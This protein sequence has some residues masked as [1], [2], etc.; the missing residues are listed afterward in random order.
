MN[1]AFI[2]NTLNGGGAERFTANI[3]NRFSEES[4]NTVYVI[5]G[6]KADNDYSVNSEVIRLNFLTKNLLIDVKQILN[7]SKRYNFD[8]IVGIDIYPNFCVCL[9]RLFSN[10]RCIISERNAPKQ[11][12]I[13]SKSR[14]LRWVL[15]RFADGYVF[16]TNGAKKFYSKRIQRKSVVIHNPIRE[17]LPVKSNVN[18]NEIVAVGRLNEQKNYPMLI[19][20]FSIVHRK[21]SDYKLRIFGEGKLKETLVSLAQELNI[22]DYVFFEGFTL[23]VHDSIKDSS[24]FVMTSDFEG[25]P[26]AL[27][28]AMAMG[29]PVVST[30]CP[31]GGPGELIQDGVNGMLCHVGDYEECE[32]KICEII[33]NSKLKNEL[34]EKAKEIIFTHSAD[35]IFLKWKEFLQK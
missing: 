19:K 34:S 24:I 27:M 14:F 23:N 28:E 7:C 35:Q 12:N 18:N 1:I 8:V 6:K 2:C 25:M 17:N 21:H 22:S 15:Y 16:Q 10:V 13:S 4:R 31:S 29:F 20:A 30:D 3:S 11:V 26:N 5:T 9:C 33:T 32:Q